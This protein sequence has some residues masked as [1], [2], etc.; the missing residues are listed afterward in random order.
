MTALLVVPRPER[1]RPFPQMR[2]YVLINIP[3]V[4]LN[5]EGQAHHSCAQTPEAIK[6]DFHL[7]SFDFH[8]FSVKRRIDWLIDLVSYN[9][10]TNGPKMIAPNPSSWRFVIFFTYCSKPL[11][12]VHCKWSRNR[13]VRRLKAKTAV[14][15]GRAEIFV[16]LMISYARE[17]TH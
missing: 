5:P 14:P 7:F 10:Y 17:R 15:D 8:S 4:M 6:I 12:N 9:S 16:S 3:D 2:L 11:Y 13:C 1:K